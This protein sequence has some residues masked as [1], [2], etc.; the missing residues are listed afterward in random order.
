MKWPDTSFEPVNLPVIGP[1]PSLIPESDCEKCKYFRNYLG[2]G[3]C[4]LFDYYP[5]PRCSQFKEKK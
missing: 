1:D 3:H 5:R 4:R 2:D